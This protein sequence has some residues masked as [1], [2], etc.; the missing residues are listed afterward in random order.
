[1]VGRQE[2]YFQN[3]HCTFSNSPFKVICKENEFFLTKHP[4]QLR[5]ELSV[6]NKYAKKALS[7]KSA[8]SLQIMRLTKHSKRYETY[9]SY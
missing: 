6:I 2:N 4:T 7:S 1:M 5:N 9:T 3:R 8:S